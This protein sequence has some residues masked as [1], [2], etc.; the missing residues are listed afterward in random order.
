MT[1]ILEKICENKKK[2]VFMQESLNPKK[3]L[4]KMIEGL[5][6]TRGFR[7]KI[8]KNFS[9][10]KISI[11]A[12]I[13]KASP[14]KG[15]ISKNFEPIKIVKKYDK[16]NAT[17]ISILTDQKY[18]QGQDRD[19]VDIRKET[20]LPILRKDF[21][22][23]DYQIYESRTLGADCI[24]L[25]SSILS[26]KK[27]LQ[28]TDLAH[29]LGLDV[30][31]E[32]HTKKELLAALDIKDILVGINNRNLKNMQVNIKNSIDLIKD[33][34]KDFNIICESG[35]NSSGD[36]KQLLSYGFKSFLIGE[37]LMKKNNPEKTLKQIFAIRK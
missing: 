35:I 9:N 8:Y 12:E 6:K 25:I 2:V 31:I 10:K 15:I 36:V 17:C 23:S 32:T 3:K 21:I 29:S 19:L 11:I 5:K 34:P 26:K 20:D 28:F 33:I 7:Q 4:I 37:Y 14:S 16:G 27:I 24:L 13:K 22:I 30:L 1:S 18:F